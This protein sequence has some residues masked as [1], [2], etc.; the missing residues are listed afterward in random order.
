MVL[1]VLGIRETNH[2]QKSTCSENYPSA[3]ID[4]MLTSDIWGSNQATFLANHQKQIFQKDSSIKDLSLSRVTCRQAALN[5]VGLTLQWTWLRLHWR[6]AICPT[7]YSHWSMVPWIPDW[8]PTAFSVQ[9]VYENESLSL[10]RKW[11]LQ[12]YP[13][14]IHTSQNIT[15]VNAMI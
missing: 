2:R 10:F 3:C 9:K 1:S 14:I 11:K 13:T 7:M 4:T 6:W 5:T 8:K 12:Y 15:A